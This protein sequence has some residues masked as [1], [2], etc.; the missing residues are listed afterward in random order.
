MTSCGRKEAIPQEC[1][2][3]EGIRAGRKGR[4]GVWSAGT[5]LGEDRELCVR[6][7]AQGVDVFPRRTRVDASKRFAGVFCQT[8][9]HLPFEQFHE[10]GALQ[11]APRDEMLW[12]HPSGIRASGP[13]RD[14]AEDDDDKDMPPNAV[15]SAGPAPGVGVKHKLVIFPAERTAPTGHGDYDEGDEVLKCFDG[16]GTLPCSVWGARAFQSPGKE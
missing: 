5:Q 7:G 12:K 8:R 13:S 9:L 15:A 14:V 16:K 11:G 1:E 4:V 10:L 3:H 2:N 6:G